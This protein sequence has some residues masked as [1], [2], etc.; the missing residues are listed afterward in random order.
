MLKLT[1][2]KS[3]RDGIGAVIRIGNQTN[4]VTTSVGYASSSDS[5]VHFGMAKLGQA[6]RI[7][8]RWPSGVVQTLRNVKTDQLIRVSEPG[9]DQ[10]EAPARNRR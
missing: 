8:I 10:R 5:I 6:E 1:G 9:S 2:K 4:H 3:N 7:E